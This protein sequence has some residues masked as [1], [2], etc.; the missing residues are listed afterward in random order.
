MSNIEGNL[1][2]SIGVAEPV[3]FG[4]FEIPVRV[5]ANGLKALVS[6]PEGA[7]K[8]ALHDLA[9]DMADKLA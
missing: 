4:S 8:Q 9:L 5:Q 2:M 7:V 6:V 1:L 3:E